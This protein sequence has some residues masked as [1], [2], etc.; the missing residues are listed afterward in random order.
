MNTIA[1]HLPLSDLDRFDD[2]ARDV[3]EKD[4][5]YAQ[6]LIQAYALRWQELG[7]MGQA[8]VAERETVE[9]HIGAAM[10]IERMAALTVGLGKSHD[11]IKAALGANCELIGRALVRWASDATRAD[12]DDCIERVTNTE[13]WSD[14]E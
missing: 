10:I 14:G 4:P 5:D 7:D 13:E 8:H 6:V 12:A 11:A 3:L 2:Y 1:G 9:T